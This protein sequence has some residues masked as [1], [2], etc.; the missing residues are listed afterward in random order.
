M[1]QHLAN[2]STV[3]AADNDNLPGVRMGMQHDMG[4]H[5]MVEQF[6]TL[7]DLDHAVKDQHLAE[8]RVLDHHDLLKRALAMVQ[9]IAHIVH[10]LNRCIGVFL[11]KL[12]HCPSFSQNAL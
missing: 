9:N 1:F 6:V 12:D 7:G 2:N 4:E 8:V 11:E 10:I 3:A 5:F